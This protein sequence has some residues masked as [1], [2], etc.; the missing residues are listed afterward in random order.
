M[1]RVLELGSIEPISISKTISG[2][3]SPHGRQERL[4]PGAPQLATR[5]P[6]LQGPPATGPARQPLY[7]SPLPPLLSSRADLHPS[8]TTSSKV[9]QVARREHASGSRRDKHRV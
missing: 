7:I 2:C 8:S 9:R 5:S 3:Q 1:A 4:G 6:R